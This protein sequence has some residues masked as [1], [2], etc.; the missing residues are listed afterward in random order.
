MEVSRRYTAEIMHWLP[1]VPD[2]HKCK[3]PH[4]HSYVIWVT[5]YGELDKVLGWVKDYADIDAIVAPFIAQLDHHNVN[6]LVPNSTAENVCLW[7]ADRIA[8]SKLRVSCIELHE[9]ERA[10]C[11]LRWPLGMKVP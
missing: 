3:N 1:N 5:V 7:L 2:G 11:V 9:T 6:D 8:E 4:G 10:K